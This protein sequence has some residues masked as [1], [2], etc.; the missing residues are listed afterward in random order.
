MHAADATAKL[1]R[2]APWHTARQTKVKSNRRPKETR[3]N[4]AARAAGAASAWLDDPHEV[5]KLSVRG[6]V[7]RCGG[8]PLYYL[9]AGV[10]LHRMR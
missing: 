3:V 8:G 7:K 2:Q 4:S 6:E 5:L 9:Q 10:S 1:H